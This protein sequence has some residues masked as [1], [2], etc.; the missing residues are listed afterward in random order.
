MTNEKIARLANQLSDALEHMDNV[1]RFAITCRTF[2][3]EGA[4]GDA[5]RGLRR[6]HK[7]IGIFYMRGAGRNLCEENEK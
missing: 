5:T 7:E 4:P 6:L 2:E 3:A 1:K